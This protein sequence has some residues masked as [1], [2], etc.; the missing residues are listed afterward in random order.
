[1]KRLII[2]VL[3]SMTFW[4]LNAQENE[5]QEISKNRIEIYFS[6]Q[7]DKA[8]KLNSLSRII[9]VDR[10]EGQLVY[11]YANRQQYRAFKKRNIPF[12]LEIP[13]GLLLKNPGMR[14]ASEIKNITDWDFYPTYDGY[15]SMM[16]EFAA[17]YPDICELIELG[18]LASGR[19]ILAIRISDNISSTEVEP[20]FLYTSSM[21]GD[22]T[23]GYVL[24][25]RMIDYI[26]SNYGSDDR[27]TEIVDNMDIYINPL[28][29]PDGTYAGGNG[30]V[31]GATRGNANGIDLNRNFPDPED[32]PH[33]DGNEWQEET[34]IFM[35]F[36]DAHDFVM[37]SNI[38]GGTEVC[39][40]PWD[41]WPRLHADDDWWQFVCHEY[42]D[43]AQAHSPSGYME[44]YDDGITNGYAWYSISGGRQDYMNYFHN[45]RE[46]TLEISN[47]KLLPASQLPAL[48]EYNYRSFLN[49]MEQLRYGLT[50][51]ITDASTGEPLKAKV[52]FVDHDQDNSM[53]FSSSD[54]G[55]YH[56]PA[57]TGSYD[58]RYSALGYLTQEI[59]DLNLTNYETLYQDISL[60]PASLIAG[61]IASN[62]IV[63]TGGSVD[64]TDQTYGSP[65]SWEWY[66]EGGTPDSSDE[67]NPAGIFYPEP[68]IYDVSLTVTDGNNSNTSLKEDFIEVD[69]FY[70]MADETITTC[71]G[72]FFDEGGMNADY[73]NDQD[74]AMTF[75]PLEN[76]NRIS[77]DFRSFELEFHLECEYDWLKI[78]NGQSVDDE[79]IGT[80]CGS[81][82]HGT[83]VADN[84]AGALTFAFHSDY[85]ETAAGWVAKI[86]CDSNV[87]LTEQKIDEQLA[88]YPNPASG[89]RVFIHAASAAKEIRI[90]D[91]RG[92]LVHQQQLN[93][94]NS[95]DISKLKKGIYILRLTGCDMTV[96][97]KFIRN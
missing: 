66:F 40:Y 52:L 53:V 95:F 45:C 17:D 12:N 93:D 5:W 23:T 13:P 81:N 29:N 83:I 74:Y 92:I 94:D 6:F 10:I 14:S 15:E 49:Y 73:Q 87:S 69:E 86:Y 68:G 63:E 19:K 76:G 50:G 4:S 8:G 46:F 35:D 37:S 96:N 42:A 67:Q 22:E 41:T 65:E 56:R 64:F 32:G 2:S 33:P 47:S 75:L 62:S 24:M 27:V 97:R 44:D 16:Y 59:N 18:T 88:V 48:W 60:E 7:L 55:N 90:F 72:F 85:S 80:F 43:T 77:V 28:A 78:Y 26:L 70:L 20:E 38:H 82:S 3:L 91:L 21:H 84:P 30:S 39:N 25:L 34:I 89:D 51:I 11:A 36:A 61:F 79:L 58:V 1:M 54:S 57:Y 9:S 31:N 71:S